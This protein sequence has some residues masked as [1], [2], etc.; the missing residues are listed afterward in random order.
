MKSFFKL[1]AIAALLLGSASSYGSI[2]TETTDV[3]AKL[4]NYGNAFEVATWGTTQIDGKMGSGADLWQFF[5]AGGN[6]SITTVD[7][8][9]WTSR[10]PLDDSQLFLFDSAG[11][12]IAANDDISGSNW[13]SSLYLE[14]LAADTYYLG[15]SGF[16]VDPM[17]RANGELVEIF[18]DTPFDSQVSADYLNPLKRWSGDDLA[19]GKRYSIVFEASV[20]EPSILLLMG[21]GLA[22]IGF[23]R[24]FRKN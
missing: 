16:D 12:G 14:N 8:T 22:G 9:D 4:S 3:G 23:S 24:R 1:T 2:I 15:I 13:L 11:I 19:D 6:L 5:F 20:P 7:T 18:P 10:N 17:T 21:V